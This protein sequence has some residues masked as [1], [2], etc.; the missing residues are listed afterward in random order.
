MEIR[1]LR[2]AVSGE[3]GI[4]ERDLPGGMASLFCCQAERQGFEPWDQQTGQRFSRPPRSTTPASLRG[5]GG[6]REVLQ[7][8]AKVLLQGLYQCVKRDAGCTSL[9]RYEL[10]KYIFFLNCEQTGRKE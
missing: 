2:E 9:S 3:Q 7:V 10:Q 5:V 4:K 1:R 6:E 8:L